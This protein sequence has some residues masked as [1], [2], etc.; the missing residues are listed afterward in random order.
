MSEAEIARLKTQVEDLIKDN[1]KLDG[2]MAAVERFQQW[3]VGAGA[4][5][6]FVFGIMSDTIKQKLG[7]K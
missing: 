1:E 7:L 2:R 6:G 3:F 4:T 5:V